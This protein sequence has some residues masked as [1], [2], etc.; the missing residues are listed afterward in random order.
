MS[1]NSSGVYTLPVA[2]FVAGTVIKSADMNSNLSDI[3]LALTQSLATTGVSSMTGPVKLSAGTLASPSLTL[4][5]DT[6]TGWYNSNTYEWSF[7]TNNSTILVVGLSSFTVNVNSTFV[8]NILANGSII[9]AS[10]ISSST[11][12]S[13]PDVNSPSITVTSATI[14][15]PATSSARIGSS[16]VNYGGTTTG[17]GFS[18]YSIDNVTGLPAPIHFRGGQCRLTLSG[19]TLNLVPYQGGMLSIG[20][21][22]RELQP[23]SMNAINGLAASNTANTFVYI[24]AY[25]NGAN[26]PSNYIGLEM[27]T[28]TPTFSNQFGVAYKSTDVSRTLVGAAYTDTGGAWAD[29][30]GKRWVLSYF[31]RKIK[32]SRVALSGT[33]VNV[34]AGTTTAEI[35]TSLRNQFI[36]WGDEVT[37]STVALSVNSA[38]A[39]GPTYFFNR[40]DSLTDTFNTFVQASLTTN[41]EPVYV[42]MNISGVTENTVHFTS[43]TVLGANNT[44]NVLASNA[45]TTPSAG[46]SYSIVEIMG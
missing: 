19:S 6:S 18:L 40:R 38:T 13:G 16:Q 4:A 10:S 43:P 2:A 27:S 7:V 41:T 11:Q 25:M 29:T 21:V 36:C 44:V 22:P 17:V 34:A 28:I 35:S 1:R 5:T 9:A 32:S 24:Y 20:G 26:A 3:A 30:D 31:N 33:T 12:L 14:S 39:G 8:G 15:A 46:A 45:T 42:Q 23:S 37:K